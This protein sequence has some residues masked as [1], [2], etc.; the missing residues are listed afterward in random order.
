MMSDKPTIDSVMWATGWNPH[1]DDESAEGQAYNVFI[2]L[3]R[4]FIEQEIDD[5]EGF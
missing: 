3:A 2:R 5:R 1:L 4:W